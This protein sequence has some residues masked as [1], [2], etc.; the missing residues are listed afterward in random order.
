MNSLKILDP[1]MELKGLELN[2]MTKNNKEHRNCNKEVSTDDSGNLV[3]STEEKLSVW[4]DYVSKLFDDVRNA[5]RVKTQTLLEPPKTE[6]E[7]EEVMAR[8][9]NGNTGRGAETV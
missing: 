7:I 4:K 8:M 9:K 5:N 6:H 2:E 3:N 1:A